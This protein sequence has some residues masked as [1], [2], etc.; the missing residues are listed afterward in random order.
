MKRLL[1]ILALFLPI[2]LMGQSHMKRGQK[3]G[4]T[5]NET[6]ID[7]IVPVNGQVT[8]YVGG[9]A[10]GIKNDSIVILQSELTTALARINVLEGADVTAPYADSAW[11][12]PSE[13]TV[14]YMKF[15]EAFD[16]DA[17]FTLDAAFSYTH[18]AV[19]YTAGVVD[20]VGAAGSQV[21]IYSS[22]SIHADSVVYVSYTRPGSGGLRDDSQ[23]YVASFDTFLVF[24]SVSTTEYIPLAYYPFNATLNDTVGDFD[25]TEF[26]TIAYSADTSL[27][28]AGSDGNDAV[29]ISN[30]ITSTDFSIAYWILLDEGNQNEDYMV[31]AN[32]Y[33]A[34]GAGFY[35]YLNGNGAGKFA[36][37]TTVIDGLG[38]S[39]FAFDAG[40]SM[41]DDIWHHIVATYD[42]DGNGTDAYNGLYLDGTKVN[43]GDSIFT[44]YADFT[45]S[46]ELFIGAE[47]APSPSNGLR[48]GAFLGE[49]AVFDH[50]LTPAEIDSL[51]AIRGGRMWQTTKNQTPPD[52]DSTRTIYETVDFTGE[53]PGVTIN[54]ALIDSWFIGAGAPTPGSIANIAV[55]DFLGDTV[56]TFTLPQEGAN[57]GVQW[58][59]D[60]PSTY[61]E[62]WFSFNF[63][64]PNDLISP[65]RSQKFPG[66]SV[67]GTITTLPTGGVHPPTCVS[68]GKAY[69]PTW[70]STLRGQIINGRIYG[71]FT[72]AA[73]GFGMYAYYHNMPYKNNASC[74]GCIKEYGENYFL[75]DENA[76]LPV[77][78]VANAWVYGA[79]NNMTYRIKVNTVT[80]EGTGDANGFVEIYANGICGHVEEN[81]VMRNYAAQL[82]DEYFIVL[83]TSGIDPDRNRDQYI[84][85]D[86][87]Q[88][89][90]PNPGSN[91]RGAPHAVGFDI[92]SFIIQK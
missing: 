84:R 1:I 22:D 32:T 54:E 13:D 23:N 15:S 56:I 59:Y 30:M 20:S 88:L 74:T 11:I 3:T 19:S 50:V 40:Y 91:L 10:T 21:K 35:H 49:L 27:L 18:G 78:G 89:W 87:F 12:L 63:W 53:L 7:S 26:N 51:Y 75:P 37:Q 17:T 2:A 73:D 71:P 83:L 14:I 60:F 81:M 46:G 77:G 6:L 58:Q 64:V 8:P 65:N 57:L 45:T 28:F 62:I 42:V 80:N 67:G 90:M 66:M 72:D 47:K 55:E 24:N 43:D 76:N 85:F 39:T 41:F 5:G 69:L 48:E 34:G 9:A 52:Y 33:S 44:N 86:D 79:W 31:F 68:C 4:N 29:L 70:G 92:S 61:G 38:G 36:L 82:L 25:G 16:V